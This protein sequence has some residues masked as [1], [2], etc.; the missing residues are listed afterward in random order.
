MLS[1]VTHDVKHY[2]A[3]STWKGASTYVIFFKS[4]TPDDS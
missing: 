4:V 3:V 1:T 2:N